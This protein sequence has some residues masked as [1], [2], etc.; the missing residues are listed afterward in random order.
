MGWKPSYSAPKSP[1]A[2]AVDPRRPHALKRSAASTAFQPC[3]PGI[4]AVPLRR[5]FEPGIGRPPRNLAR[6]FRD[7]YPGAVRANDVHDRPGRGRPQVPGRVYLY[8]GGQG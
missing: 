4:R 3:P 8:L 2:W 7:V 6:V 1:E 5:V